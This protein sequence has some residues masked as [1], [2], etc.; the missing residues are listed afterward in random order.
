MKK[1]FSLLMLIV[2][3]V[4]FSGSSLETSQSEALRVDSLERWY[5]R[6]GDPEGAMLYAY[7]LHGAVPSVDTSQ[8]DGATDSSPLTIE[9]LVSSNDVQAIVIY[10]HWF[11]GR[12]PDSWIQVGAWKISNNVIAAGDTVFFYAPNN[13]L[14]AGVI[15]NLANFS[16]I[17]P[18]TVA[19][20]GVYTLP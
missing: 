20:S 3:I 16:N 14:K 17:L 8:N 6:A 9:Q 13:S 18:P 12:I 1:I 10:D 2:F 15:E 11:T 4:M 5:G 7:P 19:Q